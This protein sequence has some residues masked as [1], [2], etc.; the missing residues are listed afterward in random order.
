MKKLWH[1]E[2]KELD[3]HYPASKW[4][5]NDL[6]LGSLASKSLLLTTTLYCFLIDD[7]KRLLDTGKE[8]VSGEKKEN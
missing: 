3:Q 4:Q 8:R 6:N 5:R 7:S 1:R 2:V